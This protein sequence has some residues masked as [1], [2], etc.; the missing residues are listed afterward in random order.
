MIEIYPRLYVGT[1]DD[2][3][4]IASKDDQWWTVHA[5]KIPFHMHYVG[6]GTQAAPKGPEYLY[7]QRGQNLALN[8]V[9]ARTCDMIPREMIDY[10]LK[11]IDD[12][13]TYS[14]LPKVLL[15]CNVGCSRSPSIGL[16]FLKQHHTDFHNLS[17][18]EAISKFKEIYPFF[19]PGKG[20]LEYL[21]RNWDSYKVVE[22]Q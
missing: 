9:D 10:A 17:L 12:V 18:L 6:Y 13:L 2:F 11:Y 20:V 19:H 8:F 15:H 21:E 4:D 22:I 7:A 1:Q 16:L 14:P 3:F 5:A